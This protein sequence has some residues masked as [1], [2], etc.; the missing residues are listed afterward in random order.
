[1]SNVIHKNFDK[2]PDKCI[3][4][5]VP[6]GKFFDKLTEPYIIRQGTHLDVI[7]EGGGSI[8]YMPCS[9]KMKYFNENHSD[10][11]RVP[12]ASEILIGGMLCQ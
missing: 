11:L 9:D 10:I 1:M 7:K 8:S 5:K 3:V 4:R 6:I 2:F 12:W